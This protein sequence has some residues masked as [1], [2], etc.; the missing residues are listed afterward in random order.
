MN[1]MDFNRK[2]QIDETIIIKGRRIKNMISDHMFKKD[3]NRR[4]RKSSPEKR[5]FIQLAAGLPLILIFLTACGGGGSG[6]ETNFSINNDGSDFKFS[7]PEFFAE[8]TFASELPLA[9]HLKVRLEAANGDIV[10]DGVDGIN[11][12]TVLGRKWVG[13]DSVQ[14]A[15][16]HLDELK[17][18]VTENTNEILVQTLQPQN[19]KV[20]QYSVDYHITIPSDL[21]VEVILD[22]GDIDVR[23][24]QNSVMVNA[25][26]GDV[27]L[28]NI[29]GSA[30]VE[31]VDGSINSSVTISPSGD[32]RLSTDNGDVD[33]SIPTST[34][35]EFAAYVVNGTI[36]TSNLEFDA[37]E[38]NSNSLTGMLGDGEGLI[39]LDTV[40]GN[41]RVV[42]FN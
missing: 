29:I 36:T 24:V 4:K 30:V 40:N 12:V 13:S 41:I 9:G 34:S 10:I 6:V 8:G 33:L 5:I 28:S 1:L 37:F 42:A 7:K 21:E 25:V 38:Q 27:L 32:I 3:D 39:E 19:S 26:N 16:I 31:L 18:L 14:D 20:R 35:A 11:S 2:R 22:N 15:K 23:D 17:I